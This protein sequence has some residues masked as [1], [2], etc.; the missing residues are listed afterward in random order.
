MRGAARTP[1]IVWQFSLMIIPCV[2]VIQALE[3]TGLIVV[4][5]QWFAPAMSIFKLPGE[6]ALVLLSAQFSVFSGIAAATALRLT[7]K[8]LTIAFTFTG[9]LHN[10]FIETAVAKRVG[11][12][13]WVILTFR[14]LSAVA[15]ALL[16][17]FLL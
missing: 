15:S 5:A 2:L 11:A 13:T 7:V 16:M 3:A 12:N 1:K 10:I 4:F 8:Q 14:L 17:A 6:A 9:C